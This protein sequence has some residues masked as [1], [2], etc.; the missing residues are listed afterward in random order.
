MDIV[1]NLVDNKE[2]KTQYKESANSPE[3]ATKFWNTYNRVC[4]I[5]PREMI[6]NEQYSQLRGWFFR[7]LGICKQIDSEIFKTIHK[8]HPYYF[9]GITSY[10]LHDYRTA[11][12]FF[13]AAVQEDLNAGAEPKTNPKPSTHFLMLEGYEERQ[14]GKQVT[15]Y[16]QTKVQRALDYYNNVAGKAKAKKLT[17][18][19]FRDKFI[20]TSLKDENH[21]GLRTL[22]SS[23]I[24]FCVEWDYRNEHFDFGI[25]DKT[26][27]QPFFLHIFEGCLLF[28]SLL[29]NKPN[30]KPDGKILDNLLN[31]NDIKA[32]FGFDFKATKEKLNKPSQGNVYDIEDLYDYIKAYDNS[33]EK[34]IHITYVARN[35]LGH[36]LGW[37]KNIKQTEYQQLCFRILSACLYSIDCLWDL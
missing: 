17:I 1:N 19:N 11:I 29:R 22:V 12:Y 5:D 31:D 9:I 26:S 3:N 33:I 23:F 4:N 25:A 37:D 13:D 32:K 14:A 10:Y 28:E 36:N 35:V 7:L 2:L 20:Y 15:E 34:T 8:G 21:L 27:S 6:K 18:E 24:I 30:P 16:A